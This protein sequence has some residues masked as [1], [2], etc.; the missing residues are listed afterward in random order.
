[1]ARCRSR[2]DLAPPRAPA[3][4]TERTRRF[5]GRG[6]RQNRTRRRALVDCQRH[7]RGDAVARSSTDPCRRSGWDLLPVAS[8]ALVGIAAVALG[9][10]AVHGITLGFGIT[11]IGESVDYSIYF[12][13]Q[14]RQP[15]SAAGARSW[16]QLV[17]AHDPLRD[18]DFRVRIR[19]AAALRVSRTQATRALLH[20]RPDR[21]CVGD[22]LC[23]A[24]AA[25][26]RVRDPRCDA[27]G[28]CAS[29]GCLRRLRRVGG[30]A[31]SPYRRSHSW[32]WSIAV[33]YHASRIHCGIASLRH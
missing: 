18:A 16:Q 14:S 33:L 10:G 3:I 17:V 31:L 21:G 9:F 2:R 20:Q 24:G 12:F 29:P 23:I 11:L 5:C 4:E 32:R 1:M 30:C 7:S 22:S 28:G 8:G 15:H 27:G 19:V 6:A 26:R 25:A 13:V